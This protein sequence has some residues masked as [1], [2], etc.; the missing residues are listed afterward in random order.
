MESFG[1]PVVERAYFA[2]GPLG[3]NHGALSSATASFQRLTID[4]TTAWPLP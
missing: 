1:F 4:G 2:L 3:H